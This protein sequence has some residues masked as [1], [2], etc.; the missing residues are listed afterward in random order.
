MS[1]LAIHGGEP[2]RT[3]PF[4]K[5]PPRDPET[6]KR[7]LQVY[8]SGQWGAAEEVRRFEASFASF[9]GARYGVAVSSGTTAL[10]IALRA[11]GVDSAAEVIVPA[12]TFFSNPLALYAS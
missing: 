9:T 4:G 8:R 10:E 2:I 1:K 11:M 3:K 5:W 12:Y 6:E 7:L